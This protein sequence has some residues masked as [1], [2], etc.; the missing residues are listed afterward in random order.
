MSQSK[1]S[2]ATTSHR[3]DIEGENS[4]ETNKLH[5]KYSPA[6]NNNKHRKPRWHKQRL[7]LGDYNKETRQN[8]PSKRPS[9]RQILFR[10]SASKDATKL[11]KTTPT[12]IIQD[13]DDQEIL[14]Q[15]QHKYL[16]QHNNNNKNNI[17][18]IKKKVVR[19]SSAP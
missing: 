1:A 6:V 3:K 17:T 2:D 9:L 13:N 5:N 15:T 12:I 16:Q 19:W 7:N 14:I 4:I 11:I 8:L 10:P 18:P